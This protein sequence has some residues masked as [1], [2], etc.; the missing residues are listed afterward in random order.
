[1]CI[2][3][4]GYCFIIKFIFVPLF[5]K[6]KKH[7]R[8][9]TSGYAPGVCIHRSNSNVTFIRSICCFS[10][11]AN[12]IV[13]IVLVGSMSLFKAFPHS[14]RNHRTQSEFLLYYHNVPYN[15]TVW[16]QQLPILYKIVPI[17][18]QNVY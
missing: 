1:M 2:V 18:L 3:P 6:R 7:C 10:D 9:F 5:L 17:S 12:F 8:S 16:V 4:L 13:V 15:C 14:L 11:F